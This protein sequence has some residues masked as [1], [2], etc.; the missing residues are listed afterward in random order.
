[1][2]RERLGWLIFAGL[3][4]LSVKRETSA[5]DA[6]ETLG[7]AF[8]RRLVESIVTQAREYLH[9]FI[10][11]ISSLL[12]SSAMFG[13]NFDN[14]FCCHCEGAIRLDRNSRYEAQLFHA[15]TRG[16]I[17]GETLKP[18]IWLLRISGR[19]SMGLRLGDMLA[20]RS[21][22]GSRALERRWKR[23]C[24]PQVDHDC[25]LMRSVGS[26]VQTA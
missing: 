9:F 15:K 3:A 16:E 26:G 6:S 13:V 7:R 10:G 17:L 8:V 23:S 20:E 25:A 2:V 4:A 18:L 14:P 24:V 5:D 1:M 19:P 11:L 21:P 22:L 12:P